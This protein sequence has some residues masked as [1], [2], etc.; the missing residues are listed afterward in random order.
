MSAPFNVQHAGNHQ[1]LETYLSQHAYLSGTTLPGK[2][3]AEGLKHVKEIP[4]LHKAPNTFAWWWNLIAF[5]DSAKALWGCEHHGKEHCAKEGKKECHKEGKKE[6]CIKEGKKE[7]T[8]EGKKEE[9]TKEGK[10]ECTKEGKKE[11]CKKEEKELDE[12]DLFGDDDEDA[13]KAKKEL[14][15]QLAKKPEKKVI[16]MKSR[17]VFEVKGYEEKQDFDELG[18]RIMK[19]INRDGLVWQD[20]FKIIPYVYGTFKLQMTMII[21]DDKVSAD[22]VLEGIQGKW[23]EEI[24]SCDI[25]EFSKA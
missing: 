17:V 11:E 2:E 21:E 10:K 12:D 9:C 14:Q 15:A 7:C 18:K 4:D 19:E 1:E 13:E 20:T 6:E 25:L 16:I 22:E 23:E 5:D 8:K 24:Q 3:D